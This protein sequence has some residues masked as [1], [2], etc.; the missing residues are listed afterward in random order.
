MHSSSTTVNQP[1]PVSAAHSTK[2]QARKPRSSASVSSLARQISINPIQVKRLT[3][4]PG[5]ACQACRSKKQK[6]DR[7]AGS[8]QSHNGVPYVKCVNCTA[9]NLACGPGLV[10]RSSRSR[11]DAPSSTPGTSRSNTHRTRSLPEPNFTSLLSAHIQPM[12]PGLRL[13]EA[14]YSS[15]RPTLQAEPQFDIADPLFSST[16]A[17]QYASHGD[18]LQAGPSSYYGSV[19]SQPLHHSILV[20]P[21]SSSATLPIMIEM[22]PLEPRTLPPRFRK[23]YNEMFGVKSATKECTMAM[24]PTVEAE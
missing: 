3:C 11:G 12:T 14:I 13:P 10:R 9:L 1:T 16:N 5:S 21:A 22:D 2:G 23:P 17:T 18:P 20:Q 8:A 19:Q 4:E 15:F 6:C 24:V 7:R